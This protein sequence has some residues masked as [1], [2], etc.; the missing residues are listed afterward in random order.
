[1]M[2]YLVLL[3]WV[4]SVIFGSAV[5]YASKFLVFDAARDCKKSRF[6]NGGF[7]GCSAPP[8]QLCLEPDGLMTSLNVPLEHTLQ[9]EVRC[10]DVG[11]R[12][13]IEVF[14]NSQ[15]LAPGKDG[16]VYNQFVM[17]PQK[18]CYQIQMA[19]HTIVG[20]CVVEAK[21]QLGKETF[22]QLQLKKAQAAR[23]L[24]SYANLK[25]VIEA[26]GIQQSL[27]SSLQNEN[28]SFLE[29]IT[30]TTTSPMDS[31]SPLSNL[32]LDPQLLEDLQEKVWSPEVM[33]RIPELEEVTWEMVL[34]A[35]FE[36]QQALF[37]MW[38]FHKPHLNTTP[39]FLK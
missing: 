11:S 30:R 34:S 38:G 13:S 28:K 37:D 25:R 39:L 33:Q 36:H 21:H 31:L 27:S 23:V 35:L 4:F 3:M 22:R 6:L 24:N 19:F 20:Q 32:I 17:P 7:E 14:H 1:M 10:K 5:S 15:S 29:G 9:L 8:A 2:K 18:S 16:S 26:F 12:V